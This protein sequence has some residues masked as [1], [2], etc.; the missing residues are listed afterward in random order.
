MNSSP[1]LYYII[2]K[3]IIWI[4]CLFYFTPYVQYRVGGQEI[5]IKKCLLKNRQMGIPSHKNSSEQQ[6]LKLFLIK[7]AYAK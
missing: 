6:I 2:L 7:Y 1:R 3:D 5:L 4:F